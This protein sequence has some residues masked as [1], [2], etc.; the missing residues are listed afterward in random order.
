[1]KLFRREFL[2]SASVVVGATVATRSVTAKADSDATGA[3]QGDANLMDGAAEYLRNARFLG[4]RF[5]AWQASYGGPDPKRS[6]YR[7]GSTAT[8]IQGVGPQVR[9]LYRL[10]EATGVETYKHAADR[11]AVF[12]LNTIHD[13]WRLA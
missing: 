4:D 12:M 10:F 2:K 5:V 7:S 8:I 11:H 3:K 9:A 13:P 6:P 1:M